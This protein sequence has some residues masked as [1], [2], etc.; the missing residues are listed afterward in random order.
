MFDSSPPNAC[1]PL[2]FASRSVHAGE[3]AP[4]P[5][6]T[7]TTTP[8]YLTNSF[9]YDD[10]DELEAAFQDDRDGYVYGRHGNPSVR[11]LEQ[12][13][14]SLEG[15][16]DALALG[17]GMAALHV[18]ILN[19]VRSGSRI[20]ASTNLYGATSAL[21][22][23]L[24]ASL[25]VRSIF[26]D[27]T[28]LDRFRAV[29]EGVRPRVVLVETISNPLMHVA[30]IAEIAQ[31]ARDSKARLIVDNTFASPYLVNPLAQGAQTVVHSTT[32]YLSGH[33]DVTGGAVASA[34]ARI[35]DMRELSRLSGAVLGPFEAWLTLRG[36]KTLPLGLEK[37]CA[38]ALAIARHLERR[39]RIAD[40]H[41]PGLKDL[42][43]ANSQFN[44]AGRGGMLSFDIEGAGQGDVF[45]FLNALELVR[46]A[47]TLGD[48]YTLALYPPMSSH[49][50]LTPEQRAA[51]GIGDGLVRLSVGIEDAEDLIADLDRALDSTT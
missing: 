4:R 9:S 15:A 28:D 2:G 31:I 47:V 39:P 1:R 27:S 20:V 21:L 38:N 16:E 6:F 14:A 12:A 42:G 44:G 30:D 22:N 45:T 32:K 46:S 29:V 43:S 17:S 5:R 48:I 25:G 3:R 33:G 23:S 51:A 40:V 18:A 19:E 13:V 35:S 41:Y 24:F 10:A 34:S 50:A 11:A 26:A 7:P 8:V 49:R 37:Q 36:V